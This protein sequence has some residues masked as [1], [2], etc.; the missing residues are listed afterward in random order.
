MNESTGEYLTVEE[1][2]QRIKFSRQTIYNLIYKKVF[3]L[4]KH[5]LKP[6]PK[7]IL[8]IWSAVREWMANPP[9]DSISEIISSQDDNHTTDKNLIN[10]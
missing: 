10:I 6:R 1:L 9:D 2:S 4:N 3:I 5:Y 8:F 7:K